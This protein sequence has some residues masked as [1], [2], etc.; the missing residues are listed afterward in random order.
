MA[1][2]KL[3]PLRMPLVGQNSR[4]GGIIMKRAVFLDRDGVI[5]RAAAEGDYVL[6]WEDFHFLPGVAEAISA[7]RHAGWTVIVVSN[8][9]CVGKGLLTIAELEAIHQ[10]MGVE[11]ARANAKLDGVY[12]C[13]HEKEPPCDCRKPSPGMFLRAAREHQID[14]GSSWMV[15][16]SESDIQAGRRAGCRTVRIAAEPS[17]EGESSDYVACNLLEASKHILRVG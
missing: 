9:R 5:N 1:I 6:R 3:R 15:G 7:M 17:A 10:R 4:Q 13:P 8:Q 14:L 11:L 2:G 16:D 12:Y